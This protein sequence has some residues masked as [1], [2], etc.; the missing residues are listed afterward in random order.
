MTALLKRSSRA[1]RRENGKGQPGLVGR[2][3]QHSVILLSICRE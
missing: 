3:A 1:I 2:V